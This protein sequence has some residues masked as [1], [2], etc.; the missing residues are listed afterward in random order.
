MSARSKPWAMT[1]P[2]RPSRRRGPDSRIDQQPGFVLHAYPWRETSQIVEVFSRDH[3]RVALVARGAKRPTSQFRGLLSPFCPLA[4]SWSGKGEVKSLVRVEWLGGLVPLRGEAL[5]AAFYVNELLVRL[6]ARGDAHESL[7][8]AYVEVLRRL[9]HDDAHHEAGL[10]S[11]ELDLLA[12]IGY[13][14][15]TDFEPQAHV[16][17]GGQLHPVS[18]VGATADDLIVS[19]RTLSAMA[20]KDFSDPRVAAEAKTALRGLIRYHLGERPLNTRRILH[21]LKSL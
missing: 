20:Q 18:V 21:D 12:E 9:A 6:L 13:G 15:A 3:G 1:E 14:L 4:L 17:R 8:G 16:L 2:A 19:P 5:L 10:R 11:F 7:F